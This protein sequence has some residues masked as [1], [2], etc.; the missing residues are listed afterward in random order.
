MRAVVEGSGMESSGYG[1]VSVHDDGRLAVKGFR[2]QSGYML[3]RKTARA[4]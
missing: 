2:A 1:V 4:G 3:R